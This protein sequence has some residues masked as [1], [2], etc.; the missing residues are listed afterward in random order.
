MRII[1]CTEVV[2]EYQDS[3]SGADVSLQDVTIC[4]ERVSVPVESES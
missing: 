3:E 1:C 4:A 2:D